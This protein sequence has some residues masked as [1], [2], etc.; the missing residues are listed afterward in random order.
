MSHETAYNPANRTTGRPNLAKVKSCNQSGMPRELSDCQGTTLK[1]RNSGP[2][3]LRDGAIVC[4]S[5]L[6]VK[7]RM[8]SL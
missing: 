3:T 2:G 4:S 8:Y 1:M 6:C 5:R 7:M